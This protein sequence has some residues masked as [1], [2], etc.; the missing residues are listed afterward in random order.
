MRIKGPTH[1]SLGVS[2]PSVATP[3]GNQQATSKKNKGGGVP[4]AAET[5]G[6]SSREGDLVA[7]YMPGG[8]DGSARS[9]GASDCRWKCCD[10]LFV[11]V[12]DLT[13]H[14][15][16]RHKKVRITYQCG[17]C[18][19]F[20]S[21]T[22]RGLPYHGR[23]CKGPAPIEQNPFPCSLCSSSYD[24]KSGHSQHMRWKHPEAYSESCGTA[25]TDRWTEREIEDLARREATLS[26]SVRRV[27]Q[28]L[29]ESHP[30]PGYFDDEAE[31]VV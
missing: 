25:K 14:V 2:F 29:Q 17:G 7:T 9:E 22:T 31:A 28:I 10:L 11:S 16:L 1:G 18:R 23:Y 27:N 30:G 21:E 24:S 3:R 12:K 20:V 26:P 5:L 8:S 15:T 6:D 4:P 13:K 19:A